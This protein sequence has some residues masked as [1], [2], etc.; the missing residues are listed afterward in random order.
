M[1]DRYP[2]CETYIYSSMLNVQ[3]RYFPFWD[4]EIDMQMKMLP[5]LVMDRDNSSVMIYKILSSNH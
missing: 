1:I 5:S 4:W 3:L 2:N